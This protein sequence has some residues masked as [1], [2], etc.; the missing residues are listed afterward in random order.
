VHARADRPA[1]ALADAGRAVAL[2]PRCGLNFH[3][4]GRALHQSHLLTEAGA[5]HL[6]AMKLGV[7]GSAKQLGYESL[8]DSVR[9][10]RHYHSQI[11]PGW[12][13]ALGS[14]VYRPGSASIFDP[15]K[16]FT[17]DGLSAGSPPEPPSLRLARC[18]GGAVEVEWDPPADSG[19]DEELRYSL[20]IAEHV[21]RWLPQKSDF[22]DGFEAYATVYEGRVHHAEIGGLKAGNK[23][24][25]RLRAHND[26]GPSQW[27]EVLEV[28]LP[29]SIKFRPAEHGLPRSWLAGD[30]SDLLAQGETAATDSAISAE[31]PAG[32]FYASLAAALRPHVA[33][34]RKVLRMHGIRA[35]HELNALGT[36]Y[37]LQV[38]KAMAHSASATVHYMVHCTVD[39]IVHYIV[40]Y[41][42]D[43]QGLL[44]TQRRQVRRARQR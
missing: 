34:L 36:P 32:T 5:A 8:L 18:E 23:Y 6:S 16:A 1:S 44:L 30:Y 33:L 22:F 2:E 27:S 39:D 17:V 29:H 3:C 35:A 20:Q 38:F 41:A 31:D 40:H 19:E 9:R 12:Q 28:T 37:A 14:G 25:L 24:E 21:V 42:S 26:R 43:L 15:R 4:Q 7:A 10:E 13:K 11:R